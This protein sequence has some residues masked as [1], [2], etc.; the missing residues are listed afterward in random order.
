MQIH[1]GAEELREA[2]SCR[3]KAVAVALTWRLDRPV[4]VT[5]YGLWVKGINNGGL[6]EWDAVSERKL[7]AFLAGE[8]EEVEVA[9][10][11]ELIE[12]ANSATTF[13]AQRVR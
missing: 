7:A 11:D 4:W 12:A 1:I 9:I 5:P 8:T 3:M 6:I 10:A 13:A 2:H